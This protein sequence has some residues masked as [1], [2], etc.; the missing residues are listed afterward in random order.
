MLAKEPDHWIALRY[1]AEISIRADKFDRAAELFK[2]LQRA[3]PMDPASWRGLAGI[4]LSRG[5]EDKSLPQLLQLARIEQGDP[6]IPAKIARIQRGRGRLRE[7]QYWFRRARFIDP[8]DVNLHAAFGDTSMQAGD[9]VSALRAYRLL[10]ALEPENAHHF[11]AAAFAA[12]K[13]GE[14]AEALKLARRAIELD[15]TSSAGSLLP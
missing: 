12:H 2:R 6:D 4:Y 14:S 8:F 3:C 5:D 15:P 7:A 9:T 11:E 10:T 1:L 13:L